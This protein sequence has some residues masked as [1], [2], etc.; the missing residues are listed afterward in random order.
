M[1]MFDG[2]PPET[3]LVQTCKIKAAQ[4][5]EAARRYLEAMDSSIALRGAALPRPL[6]AAALPRPLS[7]AAL[8]RP[9]S[10]ISCCSSPNALRKNIARYSAKQR[11]QS[12]FLQ[13]I[14]EPERNDDTEQHENGDKLRHL[15][16]GDPFHLFCGIKKLNSQ[17]GQN[18][19]GT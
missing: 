2:L 17:Y 7:G 6:S 10:G 19:D 1:Q 15:T 16:R 9:L 13:D 4:G 12:V 3:T 18:A 5:S 8:P 14:R 11:T